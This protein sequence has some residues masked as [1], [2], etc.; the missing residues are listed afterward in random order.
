MGQA[1][2]S[3]LSQ[4]KLLE[5][6][7]IDGKY[8]L[9]KLLGAGG[10]GA[11]FQADWVVGDRVLRQV[12]VKVI[13]PADTPEAQAKQLNELQVAVN[14]AHP[15]IIRCFDAGKFSISKRKVIW[16]KLELI[17]K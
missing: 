3:N 13:P 1:M 5:G 4:F 6:Q 8:H 10:F 15:H 9:I 7:V 12:A 11:V 2:N 17:R 14:L 16:H